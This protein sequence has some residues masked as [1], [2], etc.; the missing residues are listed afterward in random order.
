MLLFKTVYTCEKCTPRRP[1]C[2]CASPST[3]V[4]E[5]CSCGHQEPREHQRACKGAD[6][7]AMDDNTRRGGGDCGG[8]GLE[9]GI[10]LRCSGTR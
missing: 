7:H 8:S 2:G 4:R 6:I 5:G 9:G 1:R 10:P 3:G